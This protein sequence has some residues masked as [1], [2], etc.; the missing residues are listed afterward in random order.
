MRSAPAVALLAVNQ[1]YAKQEIAPALSLGWPSGKTPSVSGALPWIYQYD[2]PTPRLPNPHDLGAARAHVRAGAAHGP[3]GGAEPPR[4]R[5]SLSAG[6]APR[7]GRV[8]PWRWRGTVWARCCGEWACAAG[9]ASAA[10]LRWGSVRGSRLRAGSGRFLSRC[11]YRSSR[12]SARR[13]CRV[14]V[15]VSGV[16]RGG[17]SGVVPEE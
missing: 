17:R 10:G 14:C 9:A 3:G 5:L 7:R 4:S 12:L 15:R 11:A 2:A 8:G 16:L 13:Q 1:L 6:A